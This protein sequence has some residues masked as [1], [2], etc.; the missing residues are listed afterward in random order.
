M[1]AVLS[2]VLFSLLRPVVLNHC[3]SGARQPAVDCSLWDAAPLQFVLASMLRNCLIDKAASDKKE[4]QTDADS[5]LDSTWIPNK[6][7]IS[8]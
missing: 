7:L 6:S 4:L 1:L 3:G 5:E 8:C 2:A